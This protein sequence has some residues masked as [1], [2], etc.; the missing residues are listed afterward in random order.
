MANRYFL[1]TYAPHKD[2]IP[3]FLGTM[4]DGT[5]KFEK[6]LST[7]REWTDYFIASN[8]HAQTNSHWH[9]SGCLKEAAGVR[10]KDWFPRLLRP[11]FPKVKSTV[12]ATKCDWIPDTDILKTMAYCQKEHGDNIIYHNITEE[13]KKIMDSINASVPERDLVTYNIIKSQNKFC[14]EVMRL[15]DSNEEVRKKLGAILCC[16][17][18][19]FYMNEMDEA[20]KHLTYYNPHRTTRMIIQVVAPYNLI[21]TGNWNN[22]ITTLYSMWNY[23]GWA[24]NL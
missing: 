19:M 16:Y 23:R 1:F 24:F 13:Q 20:R 3:L 9:I 22:V 5:S 15:C 6:V 12:K 2:D 14:C 17:A 18:E 11:L 7:L 8:E 21:Y 10:G 4:E